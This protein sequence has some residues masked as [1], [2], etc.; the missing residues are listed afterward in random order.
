[1]SQQEE[2]REALA[3]LVSPGVDLSG[4]TPQQ[5]FAL[6]QMTR[7]LIRAAEERGYQ[8]AIS[9]TTCGGRCGT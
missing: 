2:A 5:A 8:R 6:G 4:L 9:E 3:R 1:M 7:E